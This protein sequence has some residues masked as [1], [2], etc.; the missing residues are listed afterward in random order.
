MA[1]SG[2]SSQV[3]GGA[4]R[5]TVYEDKGFIQPHIVASVGPYNSKGCFT[6]GT[7]ERAL[8]GYSFADPEMDPTLCVT[9]CQSMNF[10]FAGVEYGE[11]CYCGNALSNQTSAAP[12]S[13]CS[14]TCKGD[15]KAFCGAGNRLVVYE[16]SALPVCVLPWSYLAH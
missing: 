7:T 15:K 10:A 5:L 4:D 2:E 11:E 9:T 6:E 16:K 14:M 8:Q 13:E 1:C 3:C 12:A